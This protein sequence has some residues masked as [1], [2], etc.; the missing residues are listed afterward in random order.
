MNYRQHHTWNV[1]DLNTS[2]V[3]R[4]LIFVCYLKQEEDYYLFAFSYVYRASCHHLRLRLH[5]NDMLVKAC[6]CRVPSIH[7]RGFP[8]SNAH[9]WLTWNETPSPRETCV[10]GTKKNVFG[11]LWQFKEQGRAFSLLVLT[12]VRQRNAVVSMIN[13]RLS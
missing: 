11:D 12:E 3:V 2:P 5:S 9:V 4:T 8:G 1:Q 7:S 10:G 6:C 13:S